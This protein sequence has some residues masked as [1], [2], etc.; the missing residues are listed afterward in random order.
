VAFRTFQVQI[1]ANGTASLT[2][3]PTDT[4]IEWDIYQISTLTGNQKNNCDVDVLYNGFYL[5]NSY[6]GQKDTATG[7]PDVVLQPSDFLTINF[8]GATPGD[9]AT[10]GLWY[11]ENPT[12]TTISTAH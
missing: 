8:I 9:Y 4:A 11:N 12:G 3:R 10:V 1:T 2:I 6:Q 7:P 5:C